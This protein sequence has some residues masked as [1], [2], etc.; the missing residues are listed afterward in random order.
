[1]VN[2]FVWNIN[3]TMQFGLFLNDSA[4]VIESP[5]LKILNANDCKIAGQS[6]DQLEKHGV[7]DFALRSHSSANESLL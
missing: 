4:L 1:M 2:L 5:N 6:L 3:Y 7:F